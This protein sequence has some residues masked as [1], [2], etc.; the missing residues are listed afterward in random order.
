MR[1]GNLYGDISRKV[2]LS[3]IIC[4]DTIPFLQAVLIR[5]ILH[6]RYGANK[7]KLQLVL[8]PVANL[9]ISVLSK[10]KT[11]S[12]DF[13]PV[14]AVPYSTYTVAFVAITPGEF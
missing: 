9:S 8:F 10:E 14:Q 13:L 5:L 2:P 7:I 4:L 6:L 12:L 1:T 11:F 3:H